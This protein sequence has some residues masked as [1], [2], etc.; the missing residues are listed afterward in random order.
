[1]ALPF[2]LIRRLLARE[3]DRRIIRLE[4]W[5]IRGRM[6]L[7][8]RIL[9]SLNNRRLNQTTN[10]AAS[11]PSVLGSGAGLAVMP[12]WAEAM[13]KSATGPP[14]RCRALSVM[15][16]DVPPRDETCSLSNK[17]AVLAISS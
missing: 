4:N 11:I 7:R 17:R 12:A 16:P 6:G 15:S 3:I 1:Q 9:P 14:Y 13:R 2:F 8:H 10:P 5:P